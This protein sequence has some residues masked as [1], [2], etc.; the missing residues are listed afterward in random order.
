M[1][2]A[3]LWTFT[4]ENA[5]TRTLTTRGIR[6]RRRD[7]VGPWMTGQAGIQLLIRP[8]STWPGNHRATPASL[9]AC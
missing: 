7:Y 2:A 8:L 1:P 4:L 9:T 6:F 3:D 5:G